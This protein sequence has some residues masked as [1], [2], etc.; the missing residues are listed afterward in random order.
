MPAARTFRAPVFP[1]VPGIEPLHLFLSSTRDEEGAKRKKT[2][3]DGAGTHKS[4]TQTVFF[5]Q[6]TSV[7][8]F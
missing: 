4:K 7:S 1:E 6:I 2:N 5:E 3:P 8:V